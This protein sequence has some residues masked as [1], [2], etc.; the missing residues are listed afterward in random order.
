M[1]RIPFEPT[2]TFQF[3]GTEPLSIES[4]LQKSYQGRLGAEPFLFLPHSSSSK[5]FSL[6]VL[7]LRQGIQV[8]A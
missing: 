3:A 4:L 6:G 1:D 8:V 7:I 5:E 2:S